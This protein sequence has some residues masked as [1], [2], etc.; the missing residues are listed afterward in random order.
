M[1][2]EFI[3]DLN[4]FDRA[5]VL[6]Y[7]DGYSQQEMAHILGITATNAGTRIGRIKHTLQQRV[8]AERNAPSRESPL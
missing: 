7:L 1:L 3:T 2:Y 5:L 6:L 4:P 8:A